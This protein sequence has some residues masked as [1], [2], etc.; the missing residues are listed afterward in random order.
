MGAHSGV[1]LILPDV[2]GGLLAGGEL[3]SIRVDGRRADLEE[4]ARNS[5]GVGLP[6]T[7]QV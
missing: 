3:D 1:F 2:L 6:S 5:L 7:E 4:L